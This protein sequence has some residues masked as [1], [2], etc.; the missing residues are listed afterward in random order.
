MSC[1][2]KIRGPP[3]AK[4][5]SAHI[6]A[7]PHTPV[8]LSVSHASLV[9]SIA[10]A[11]PGRGLRRFAARHLVPGEQPLSRRAAHATLLPRAEVEPAQRAAE[12][13]DLAVAVSRGEAV[14]VA[15]CGE[16]G[17]RPEGRGRRPE[18]RRC[19]GARVRGCEG[20]RVRGARVARA[21]GREGAAPRSSARLAHQMREGSCSRGGG[22][23]GS[24]AARCARRTSGP[25]LGQEW[26]PEREERG[27]EEGE[28]EGAPEG[29]REGAVEARAAASGLSSGLSAGTAPPCR[30]TL[31][32]QATPS[33]GS[34]LLLSGG[35]G[36]LTFPSRGGG[37]RG[38]R[39]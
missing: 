32:A 36:S 37:G 14:G 34:S 16:G 30:A 2:V 33:R 6:R 31:P 7:A 15:A 18:G 17:G 23:R 21:Q 20:A 27:A 8:L 4:T 22:V 39:G 11:H 38:A 3:S 24:V 29:A 35:A 5:E 10:R 19:E 28:V 26:H 9:R 25:F 12:A 1:A 13:V